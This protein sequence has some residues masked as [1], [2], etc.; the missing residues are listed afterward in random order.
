MKTQPVV[1]ANL[2]FERDGT[3]LAPDFGDVYHARAGALAQA[4]HVFLA[5]NRLPQ[6]W[7]G[8]GRFVVL[9]TG[10]GLGNNFL[11][12][13]AA[14]RDDPR[15]CE[16]LC[17]VSIEKHPLTRDDLERVHSIS[18]LAPLA[19][20]LIGAWPP[21]VP[22]LHTLE[23]DKGQVVLLLALGDVLQWLPEIVADVD[24]FYLDGFAPAKNPS[25]WE[26]HVLRALGRI[27]A[28]G[29]TAATW[30][31]AREVRDG[32]AGAGFQVERAQG[33]GDKREMTVARFAPAFAPRRPAARARIRREREALVIGAGLAGASTARALAGEGIDCLVLEGRPAAALGASGNPAG[34]FH[35]T[36]HADD[37]PHARFNRAAALEAARQLRPVVESGLVPGRVA[38]LI[39]LEAAR[40]AAAIRLRLEA[41]GLPAEYVQALEAREAAALSALPLQQ[42]AWFY[43]GGGWLDPAALVRHWLAGSGIRLRAGARVAQ[44][45]RNGTSWQALDVNGRTLGQAPLVVLA[46]AHDT[47]RLLHEPPWPLSCVRGQITRIP[48]GAVP[49]PRIPVAG[50]GYALTLPD[51]SV[52]CGATSDPGDDDAALRDA[53][54]RHNL[55]R[56]HRITGAWPPEGTPLDGRVGWR[57]TATDRLPLLGAMPRAGAIGSRLDQ[58]RFVPREAGL[59]VHAGLGS[60]GI[61]WAPLAAQAMAAWIAGA[62]LPLEAS[63][64]DAIDPARFVSRAVRRSSS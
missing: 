18:P 22:S 34:L 52:L 44:L 59:F 4:R 32:L 62:P 20:Q 31:V 57:S 54:H 40:D 23:F 38:G 64:L 43:P 5:G 63:L 12:T 9:E 10:F 41:L 30:S 21:L 49:G 36:L 53:D 51:G 13:W 1:P 45:R 42:P 24:A 47:L 37:G 48:R 6:R 61:T 27:A 35:G 50:D 8:R 11:A 56:L 3:P 26:R 7:A 15:R 28:D 60:R 46:A 16:R 17:F 2:A 14:W 58:P 19:R 55:Q 33:F 39:R 29:A 25:M